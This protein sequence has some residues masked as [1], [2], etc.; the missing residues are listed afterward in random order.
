MM[1]QHNQ[2]GYTSRATPE[3]TVEEVSHPASMGRGSLRYISQ[4]EAD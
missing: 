2:H 1:E 4:K 3:T